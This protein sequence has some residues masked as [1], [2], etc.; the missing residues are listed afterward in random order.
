MRLIL[1]SNITRGQTEEEEKRMTF[2]WT[3]KES[4]TMERGFK[5]NGNWEEASVITQKDFT[6]MEKE[7]HL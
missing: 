1:F 2:A 4:L 7:I 6:F 5:D 3:L